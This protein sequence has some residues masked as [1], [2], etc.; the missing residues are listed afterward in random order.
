MIW[1]CQ[2]VQPQLLTWLVCCRRGHEVL[3]VGAS[4]HMQFFK[5]AAARHSSNT[6]AEA[7]RYIEIDLDAAAQGRKHVGK[8]VKPG[9]VTHSRFAGGSLSQGCNHWQQCN[10]TE[11]C[12]CSLRLLPVC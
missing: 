12:G 6:S 7:L 8:Q 9:Q 3:V 2:V 10:C 4:A 11:G 1:L 5:Q